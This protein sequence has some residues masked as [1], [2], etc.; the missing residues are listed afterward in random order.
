[1]NDDSYLV[2]SSST[3]FYKIKTKLDAERAIKYLTN[4]IPDL[5]DRA[6]SIATRWNSENP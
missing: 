5:K 2:G 3:G 1:M 6:S 4:R